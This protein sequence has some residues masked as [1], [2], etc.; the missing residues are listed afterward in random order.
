M[1]MRNNNDKNYDIAILLMIMLII[2]KVI[3]TIR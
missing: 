1:V 3:L 2:R